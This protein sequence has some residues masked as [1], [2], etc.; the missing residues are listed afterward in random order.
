MKRILSTTALAA[1]MLAGA[2]Q[3]EQHSDQMSSEGPFGL[4]D[5]VEELQIFAS[6]MIGKRIYAT[7]SEVGETIESGAEQE[8]NDLGEVN[9]LLLGRDGEI[10][11]AILGIGGFLGIGERDV[12]VNMD[13]L[14]IAR[15]GDDATDYFLILNASQEEIENAPEF[16]ST[17]VNE[18]EQ[19]AENAAEGTEEAAEDAVETTEDAV[20]GVE[21]STENAAEDAEQAAQDAGQAAENAAED[22][23]QATENAA[24]DA[25]EATENAAENA[26]E[27]TGEAVEEAGDEIEQ[28]TDEVTTSN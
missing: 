6:D 11:F 15:D 5:D 22:A 18:A 9:D 20:E 12:L 16:D 21:Q 7:E 3:A 1:M 19:A 10:D 26:A 14:Q 23:E 24:E 4:P 13:A 25:A 27:E 8:W 28:E 2:A 17:A